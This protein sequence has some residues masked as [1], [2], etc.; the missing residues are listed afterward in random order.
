MQVL[1]V[2]VGVMAFRGDEEPVVYRTWPIPDD[3]DY[4]QPYVQLR[5]PTNAIGR[6]RFEIYDSTGEVIFIHEDNHNLVRG[7]NLITPA[8]RMPIHDERNMNGNWTIRVSADGVLLAQHTFNWVE[9][10]DDSIRKHIGEDGELTTELRA[11]MANNRLEKMTLDELLSFQDTDSAQ[12][13][14]G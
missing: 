4:I 11:V 3:V 6:V 12:Q 5:L 9:A 7:R 1:P 2:D 8:S 13:Q 10:A 14:S